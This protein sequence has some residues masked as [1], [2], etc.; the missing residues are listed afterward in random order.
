MPRQA[1]AAVNDGRVL[2]AAREV[3]AVQGYDAPVAAVAQAAGVGIAS[4]YRRYGSKD[5]LL[6]DVC[7]RSMRETIEVAER[8][9]GLD[10]DPLTRLET[11]VR[12]CVGFRCGALGGVAGRI[13]V[14]DEMLAAARR[15]QHLAGRLVSE[16]QAR[17]QVRPDLTVVDVLRLVELFGRAPRTGNEPRLLAIALAGLAT[18]TGPALPGPAPTLRAYRQRWAASPGAAATDSDAVPSQLSLRSADR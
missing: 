12:D 15:S 13:P 16:A 6:A 3:F 2:A 4:L 17:G 9:L 14:S 8:A 18:A 10:A 7:L 11:F 5:E 1:E